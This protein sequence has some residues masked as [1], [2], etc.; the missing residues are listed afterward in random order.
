MTRSLLRRSLYGF[1]LPLA[2]ALSGCAGLFLQFRALTE[3][4]EAVERARLRVV[5][6]VPVRAYPD[7]SCIAPFADNAGMVFGPGGLGSKGFRGRS[8]DMPGSTSKFRLKDH[9]VGELYV[10]ADEPLTLHLFFDGPGTHATCQVA[11]TFVPQ[12]NQDYEATLL[13]YRN[14]CEASVTSL[15]QPDQ[16]VDTRQAE[17][18]P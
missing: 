18:C 8:L 6:N 4:P 17:R 7:S 13:L 1:A 15:S 14:R 10:A 12:A 2:M 16:K 9:D 5:A 3:P 11:V